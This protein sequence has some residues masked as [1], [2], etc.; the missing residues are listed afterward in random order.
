MILLQELFQDL[1]YGE[2]SQFTITGDID[3]P[4]TGITAQDYPAIVSH[5]NKALTAL[6]TRLPLRDREVTVQLNDALAFYKLSSEYALTNTG[7]TE[8][9]KYIIDSE[10][11]PFIDD[12]LG[13]TA[14]YDELGCEIPLNDENNCNSYWLNDHRTLQVVY[15]SSDN[16]IFVTYRANHPKIEPTDDP[17]TTEIDIPDFCIEPVLFYIASRMYARSNDAG[18]VSRSLEMMQKYEAYCQEI[19]RRNVLNNYNNN[20][21]LKLEE[22][23]F[24]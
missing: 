1:Q 6:H 22:R 9:I 3:E 18:A 8:P 21:N 10:E 11:R 2:L 5:L 4:M 15:P 14:I 17:T 20:T 16:A 24:V 12:V 13:V 19:E 7:S 23:G